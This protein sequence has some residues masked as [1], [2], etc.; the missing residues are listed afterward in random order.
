MVKVSLVKWACDCVHEPLAVALPTPRPHISFF[1]VTAVRVSEWVRAKANMEETILVSETTEARHTCIYFE[2]ECPR[3]QNL[4]M[5][6]WR[7]LRESAVVWILTTNCQDTVFEHINLRSKGSRYEA[8]V[9]DSPIP[10]VMLTLVFDKNWP[11]LRFLGTKQRL[12]ATRKLS[13]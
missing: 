5:C 6:C 12:A 10:P 2:G 4:R 9:Q 3:R 7:S 1:G 13:L 8:R 11:D